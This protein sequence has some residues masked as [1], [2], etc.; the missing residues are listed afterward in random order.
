[1]QL[2]PSCCCFI[3]CGEWQQRARPSFLP[4]RLVHGPVMKSV[5]YVSTFLPHAHGTSFSRPSFGAIGL[6]S[7]PGSSAAALLAAA[8]CGFLDCTHMSWGG[9]L[10]LSPPTCQGGLAAQQACS[11]PHAAAGCGT[12]GRIGL[13][14][15]PVSCLL[16][17]REWWKRNPL[18][19]SH[20]RPFDTC[21]GIFRSSISAA[22]TLVSDVAPALAR[23]AGLSIMAHG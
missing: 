5:I 19:P 12:S 3:L 15:R 20:V 16:H 18:L 9:G 14:Y 11:R 2:S 21:Q 22:A 1:M 6:D 4:A 10:S 13:G 17:E 7:C 23:R 8:L